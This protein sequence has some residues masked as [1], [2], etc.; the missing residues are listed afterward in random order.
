MQ[1]AKLTADELIA[2]LLADLDHLD[3]GG[4]G[5]LPASEAAVAEAEN[6][7]GLAVPP[8]LRRVY[9]EVADGGFGPGYGA[10]SMPGGRPYGDWLNVVEA[11]QS[12]NSSSAIR[13]PRWL[14]PLTDWGCA[15]WS[16]VDC[17]DDFGYV[18]GFDPNGG[19]E[20]ALYWTE[21]TVAEWLA[22]SLRG[23]VDQPNSMRRPVKMRRVWNI[24]GQHSL[25]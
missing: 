19:L 14:M 22:E 13:F 11:W 7:M 4:A 17:R 24:L 3:H 12:L 20:Q 23:G 21:Q 10:Q 1:A 8:V 16:L 5:L 2:S 25:P 18:W 6:V 9:L 15:I